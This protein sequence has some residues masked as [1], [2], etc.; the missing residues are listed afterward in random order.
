MIIHVTIPLLLFLSIMAG[1]S[2]FVAH[3]WQIHIVRCSLLDVKKHYPNV[4]AIVN[5]AN[6]NMRG[7]GGLDGVIHAA[8]GPQLLAELK[9]LVPYRA[10]TAQV[11][12]TSG[13][14]TGFSH[15]LHVAGPIYSSSNR[16]ESRN[17]LEA[18]Y[19][20]VIQKADELPETTAL[21]VA[22]ISTGIYGYPL[23]AAAPLAIATVTRELARAQNLKTVVF[24]MFGQ[25]EFDVFTKALDQWKKER[26]SDL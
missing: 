1:T 4:S 7:G 23:N 10:Q 20:N 8:A 26:G 24:A 12:V 15:I 9:R 2:S 14:Q 3:K 22:S 19:T 21:G 16:D 6:V 25:N 18:T 17:L 5:A 13:Y 11:I